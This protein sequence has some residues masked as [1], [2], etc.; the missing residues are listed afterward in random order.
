MVTLVSSSPFHQ[1]SGSCMR[2]EGV[3]GLLEAPAVLGRLV[4]GEG[5]GA[6]RAPP[7]S[8]AVLASRPPR[9]S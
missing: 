8:A 7:S 1:P 9:G 5:R 4:V 3:D 6:A 2:D